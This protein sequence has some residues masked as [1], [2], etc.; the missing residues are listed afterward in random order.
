MVNGTN[1]IGK[2]YKKVQFVLQ[3][4]R[5]S[6]KP[7]V[8]EKVLKLQ[9]VIEKMWHEAHCIYREKGDI[10]AYRD[11]RDIFLNV[12]ETAFT[13]NVEWNEKV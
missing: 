8:I 12:V 13:G 3:I 10:F 7:V 2:W 5:L 9:E 1:Y 6:Q 4:S 11:I